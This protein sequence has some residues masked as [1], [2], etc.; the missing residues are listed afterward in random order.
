M[1][2]RQQKQRQSAN[3]DSNES[4]KKFD[5]FFKK[6][7]TPPNRFENKT[8]DRDFS[9]DPKTEDSKESVSENPVSEKSSYHEGFDPTKDNEIRNDR[10]RS[11][12]RDDNGRNYNGR[13]NTCNNFANYGNCKFGDSCR[14]SHD[15][16]SDN[17]QNSYED[18]NQRNYRDDRGRSNYRDDRGRSNYRDDRGRSNYRDDRGRNNFRDDNG[19]NYNGRRNTCNNFERYGNCKFGDSCRFSH[20][21]QSDNHQK[22][23]Q[24]FKLNSYEDKINKIN[25]ELTSDKYISKTKKEE[26]TKQLDECK[27]LKKNEF[28]S[29]ESSSSKQAPT[30]NSCWGNVSNKVKSNEGVDEANKLTKRRMTNEMA[31]KKIEKQLY[32]EHVESDYEGDDFFDDEIEDED[33]INDGEYYDDTE[34][35]Y[36]DL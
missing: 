35:N 14:F 29:L 15:N 20:D 5:K 24:T 31:K 2:W 21:I 1:A 33:S 26:L 6:K 27:E 12:F 18:N 36:K 19:R 8:Y 25:E 3:S 28:P 10:G 34:T 16:P 13:R 32:D 22:A 30:I 11:N 4:D 9:S 23:E 7:N 17:Q